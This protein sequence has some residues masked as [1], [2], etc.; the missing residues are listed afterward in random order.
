MKRTTILTTASLMIFAM[1]CGQ[2]VQKNNAFTTEISEQVNNTFEIDKATQ[3]HDSIPDN[4]LIVPGVRAGNSV[5]D[6][7]GVKKED[8]FY[9]RYRTSENLGTCSTLRELLDVYKNYIIHID[10]DMTLYKSADKMLNLS[11]GKLK[12]YASLV[13][14]DHDGA[15]IGIEFHL[16]LDPDNPKQEWE[17]WKVEIYLSSFLS[18]T[19]PFHLITANG[20]KE[21]I[22]LAP[23][24][25]SEFLRYT[26]LRD[27]EYGD[28][29][30]TT[31]PNGQFYGVES[32]PWNAS[33]QWEYLNCYE[34][35]F[36]ATSSLAPS[37][38]VHYNVQNI[39]CGTNEDNNGEAKVGSRKVTWGKAKVGSRK[40]TWCEGVKGYGIGES[41]TMSITTKTDKTWEWDR[42]FCIESL[43]IVNGYAKD[44]TTWKNNSRV[45]TL[46]LYVGDN[47]WCDLCLAD[48]IKPQI[49][50]FPIYMQI[51]PA[52]HGKEIPAKG[53]FAT[54]KDGAPVYQTELRFEI[55]EVYP[56]DKYDDT[57][58]T[59]I[60]VDFCNRIAI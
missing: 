40:V 33:L 11:P 32:Y 48:V 13:C 28:H 59:G 49:F 17:V 50:V 25:I 5:L 20:H 7:S 9:Y 12:R 42:F 51:Y 18:G 27:E 44:Q 57:C 43:M 46:Q 4:Y 35:K 54:F 29:T 55:I 2:N 15:E 23:F 41:V 16:S 39:A 47:Y 21:S 22:L 45:K 31:D 56:G 24:E 53:K 30:Y 52:K 36:A 6:P 1:A 38:N 10:G 60:T 8:V 58:I 19:M 14:F 3:S 37:G 26:D 34:E